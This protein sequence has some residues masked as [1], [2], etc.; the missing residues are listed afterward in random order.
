MKSRILFITFLI[1]FT[2]IAQNGFKTAQKRYANV[3]AAYVDKEKSVLDLLKKH[4]L[5]QQEVQIHIRVYKRE[6]KIEL[7][8]KNKNDQRFLLLKEFEV[9]FSSGD[10]G[11]KRRKY[12]LQVPEGFYSISSFNP[13]SSNFLSLGINYPN[14]SDRVLGEKGNLGGSI[15]IHGGCVSVGCLPIT[16]ELIKEIYIYCVEAKNNGEMDI[17]ITIF[18]CKMSLVNYNEIKTDSL[19]NDF[20][21]LWEDLKSEYDYF[22]EKQQV[23][24]VRFL[25][26]GRHSLVF[27]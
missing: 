20:L 23:C 8:A 13:A 22:S 2:G 11:P 9:C 6:K 19:N 3:R 4:Q 12:D 27:D 7:W 1:G 21:G 15:A 25:K 24:K 26:S 14:M 10:L 5:Y 16:N 18:S 17:P